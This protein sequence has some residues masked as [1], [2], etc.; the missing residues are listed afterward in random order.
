MRRTLSALG[1]A[2]LAIGT[3]SPAALLDPIAPPIPFG[4]ELSW[5]AGSD[6]SPAFTPDGRTVFFTHS[7][8]ERRTIMVAHPQ[9][10]TWSKPEVDPFSG[11]WRDI[12]PAMA[13]DGTY[14]IFFTN[15]PAQD[16]GAVLDGFWGGRTRPGAEGNLWRVDREASG[17]GKPHRLPDIVNTNSAIY[18]PAVAADGS[19]YFNQPD[20]RTR[21]SHLYRAQAIPGGFLPAVPLPISDGTIGDFD[22]AVAPNQSFIIFSSGRPPAHPKQALLF[23]SYHQN[24]TWTQP[25]ARQPPVEGLEARFGPGL[26]TL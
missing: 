16:R 24:A 4:P 23:V 12:E 3:R 18:S 11:S 21:M 14:L 6:A 25:R 5:P 7:S 13:P 10:E 17:W 1:L 15:R 9:G 22:A 19:I 2:L 26:K 8:G 20:P